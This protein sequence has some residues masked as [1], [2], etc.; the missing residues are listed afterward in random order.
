MKKFITFVVV[1]F[2][3]TFVLNLNVIAAPSIKVYVYENLLTLPVQ[4]ISKNGNIIV[5]LKNVSEALGLKYSWDNKLKKATVKN[6]KSNI[7]VSVS[8]KTAYVNG[9]PK[10][11]DIAPSLAK[12]V[13]T[14]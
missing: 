8:S 4:P 3:L 9:K 7:S 12:N 2:T 10:S 14:L 11:L 5:P 1:F 13:V 6:D